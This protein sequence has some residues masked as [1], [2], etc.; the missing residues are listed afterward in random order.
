M[1]TRAIAF[2]HVRLGAPDPAAAARDWAVVLGAVPVERPGGGFR[3]QLDRGAL[4][5]AAGPPGPTTLGFRHG[6]ARRG[7]GEL[8]GIA[9][10]WVAVVGAPAAGSE[11]PRQEGPGVHDVAPAADRA[12]AI[13][14]VVVR[15]SDPERV[16]AS[17]R[18]ELGLRLAL[19]RSFPARGLRMLFFRSA[20]V[21]L[22][23]VAPIDSSGGG[24]DA[25]DGIAWQVQDLDACRARLVAEGLDV[26][27]VRPGFKPGTRVATLRSGTGG[28]PTLLIQPSP[29]TED[30][31]TRGGLGAAARGDA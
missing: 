23:F 17:W 15:T 24:P 22:E 6:D 8:H 29:R 11:P 20:G 30:G 12:H 1:E 2:D 13:D 16:I 9:L 3:F 27:E 4:E 25:I 21:T 28:L 26:S 7:P 14:H 18:D 5:I 19:D 10:E 31:E